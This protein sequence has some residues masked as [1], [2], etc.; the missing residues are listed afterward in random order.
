MKHLK[1]FNESLDKIKNFTEDDLELMKT[2]MDDDTIYDMDIAYDKVK[3]S[4]EI[5]LDGISGDLEDYTNI[6][7]AEMNI[8]DTIKLEFGKYEYEVIIKRVE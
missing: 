6:V 8:K 7:S 5:F 1:R 2:H 3:N 4:F